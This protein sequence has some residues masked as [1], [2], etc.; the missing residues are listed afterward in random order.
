MITQVKAAMDFI[1]DSES[2]AEEN[3]SWLV[4]DIRKALNIVA[5]EDLTIA[6]AAVLVATL[7]PALSRV[8]SRPVSPPTQRLRAV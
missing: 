4:D 7:G 3:R 6:E 2:D 5:S 1:G 8:I